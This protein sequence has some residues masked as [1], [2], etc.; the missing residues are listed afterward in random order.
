MTECGRCGDCCEDI[1]LNR[2]KVKMR[3]VISYGDPRDPVTMGALGY[4]LGQ[5]RRRPEG[6]PGGLHEGLPRR[7]V[8]HRALAR[9]QEGSE[10][11][12]PALDLRP[13]RP[14]DSALYG[15]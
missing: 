14:R 12:D 7:P 10:G 3:Q 11:C 5:E 13:L 6:C 15:P 8:H 4:R 2:T 9:G 1:Y